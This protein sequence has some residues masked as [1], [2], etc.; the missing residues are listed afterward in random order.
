VVS[1]VFVDRVCL[2]LVAIGSLSI[3]ATLPA[4]AETHELSSST[5]PILIQAE[6][7]PSLVHCQSSLAN[8]QSSI[9]LDQPSLVHCQSSIVLDQPSFVDRR[10]SLVH[11]QSS[12]VIGHTASQKQAM[13]LEQSE[14]QVTNDQGQITNDPIPQLSE[15][16][17]PIT[18]IA[19][20]VAQ[21]EASLVQI[22]GVRV[23]ETEAGLQVILE[24]AEGSLDAPETRS[25][26]NALIVDIPNAIIAEEFSQSE[27]IAGIALVSVTNLPDN[28]VRVAITGTDATPV[29]EV[30][31]DEQGLVLAVTIGDAD[32]AAEDDAIQV[33]VTG[34]Q[35]TGYRVPDAS[36]GTRTDTPI[37]DVPASIQVVPRQVIDDRA[38][39]NLA[40]ALETTSGVN[41]ET[42][43]GYAFIPRIRGF[44][45]F[46]AVFVNGS[47]RE[48][49]VFDNPT[50]DNIERVEVLR[51][52][53]SVLFGQG[54]PG[55][56][57]N[58]VTRRPLEDPYY[59]F[60]LQGGSFN[61]IRP[62]F[63]V[64]GLLTDDES[65]L[66]RFIGS[67]TREESFVEFA[68]SERYFLA[69][70]LEW[71][72][73]PDTTL[74]ADLEFID[75]S[76]S[77][78]TCGIPAVGDGVAD[79][80]RSRALCESGGF[81]NAFGKYDLQR[82]NLSARLD[83]QFSANWSARNTL[84]FGTYTVRRAGPSS[85][86]FNESTGELQRV[87]ANQNNSFTSFSNNLDVVGNFSTGSIDHRLLLGFE[88]SRQNTFRNFFFGGDYPSINIFDPD[89]SDIR[90]QFDSFPFN[91][92]RKLLSTAYGFYL[93]DQISF[94]DNLILVLGGRYDIYEQET[95]NRI[96]DTSSEQEFYVFSP[97]VGLV[98]QP[99]E[100]LSLYASFT[101]GFEPSSAVLFDGSDPDPQRS[102]QYEVGAKVEFGDLAATLA[103]FDIT[104]TN[105]PTTDPAN[106]D[107]SILTGEVKSRGVEFDITGE[108]LPGWNIT[109][110][111]AYTDAFVSEDNTTPVGNRFD[112]VPRHSAALWTTYEI[113]AGVVEGLGFG[114]GLFYV[115]ERQA[116][117][118]NSF[119]VP[120]YLRTDASIFYRRDNWR[121]QVN[122]RNI[123]DAEYF[124]GT[125]GFRAG[126]V[127]PGP[128]FSVVGSISVTF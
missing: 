34:E 33:V 43:G 77:S 94:T 100:P 39:T 37:R 120:S 14:A 83:H 20:W 112:F 62:S 54:N 91:G 26:G 58:Y 117:L 114:L 52:P 7:E 67:Y 59:N 78:L 90:F 10:S 125:N 121:A 28:R 110:S 6:E 44:N 36:V 103:Y 65:L 101:Q 4:Q 38:V 63:D 21:I 97:R 56:I 46:D 76:I 86:D 118:A 53:S 116:D 98:Y 41:P 23:E 11:C 80:P 73:T 32:A 124:V 40:D 79:I 3:F 5:Q 25:I 9:V 71:R 70:S 85:S 102:T 106:P 68:N 24:T 122:L 95:I 119:S 92:R 18:T 115:D 16:E 49:V 57:I 61:Q 35:N 88:Y 2:G 105:I 19:D 93:Q 48:V 72:I 30:R 81:G 42:Y 50:T 74:A 60:T 82:Y 99:V 8:C 51:G 12:L 89:Y 31:S 27:P 47:R 66:Y 107:F 84:F 127:M 108:I 104:R 69:P 87:I 17:Q 111:Y 45:S 96:E 128:P 123:F 29:A 22:T 113:Q 1:G 109:A 55:G 75:S 13:S 126:G 64:S 15:L